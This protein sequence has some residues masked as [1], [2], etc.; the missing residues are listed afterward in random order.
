MTATQNGRM[1]QFCKN[2][3]DTIQIYTYL[4]K[5]ESQRIIRELKQ[6]QRQREGI[7]GGV[8]GKQVQMDFSI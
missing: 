7:R 2:N 5:S 1:S 6:P 4:V 3:T 8:L